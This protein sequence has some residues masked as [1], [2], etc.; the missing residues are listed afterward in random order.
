[1]CTDQGVG[2]AHRCSCVR[3]LQDVE[4]YGF[5]CFEFFRLLPIGDLQGSAQRVRAA[6]A[7]EMCQA[8]LEDR[9]RTMYSVRVF[10][11]H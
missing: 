1:M 4:R 8:T 9:A 3:V 5:D 2:E 7:G 11:K 10:S 6:D